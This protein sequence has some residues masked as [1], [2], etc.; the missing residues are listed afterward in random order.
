MTIRRKYCCIKQQDITDCGP[1]CIGTIAM[2]YG[3]KLS[4]SKLREI[5]GT[6]SEGTS[7]YGIME[8]A[9]SLGFSA[10]AVKVSSNEEIFDDLK[11]PLIAHVVVD[12][13]LLHYVVIHK[14]TKESILIA[15]PAKGIVKYTPKEF[16]DIWTGV[17]VFMVP[18]ADF[19]KGDE[20]KGL[21]ERFWGLIKI[22][23]IL[24]AE[25]FISSIIITLF[26]IGGSFYFQFLIDDILPNNLSQKLLSISMAMLVL[27]IFKILTEFFRRIL[28][29]HMAQ[30][31]DIPLLLGYYNHVINLPMKFFSTRK[32][33]EI[34][35]RFN[36]GCK[37]R[38]AISSATLTLM[39]DVLMAIVGGIILYIQSSKLFFICSVP[40]CLYLILVFGFK[41]N[42]E[43]VNRNVMEDDA[44]LTSYL[45][46]SIEGIETVKAFNGEK[47]VKIET[48]AKFM[49]FIKSLFK[50]AYIYNLQDT[51]MNAVKG[52]FGVCILWIGGIFVLNRQITI[53]ELISFNALLVYYIGPIERLINLQPQ[54]Q[55]AVVASDRLG[56]ILDLEL[57]KSQDEAKKINPKSLSGDIVLK[58]INFRYGLR[59]LV[60]KNI[61]ISIKP[62]EKIALVGES[63]SGKTT[64][65][66]LLM[67]FYKI[68]KGEIILNGYNIKDINKE[69][70]RDKISYVSQESFL[71]SG[72][73]KENLQFARKNL[74][75][76]DI[77]SICK[78][79]EIHDY[80]NRLPLKYE[81]PLVERGS[82]LSGGQRQRLS[83][84]RALL[85]NPDVLIMDEATSNLDSITEKAIQKTLEECSGNVTSII[86]AH[87]L[88]TIMKCDKIY[89]IDSGEIVEEGTHKELLKKRGYYYRLWGEQSI[90][91]LNKSLPSSINNINRN[92]TNFN[93]K[94]SLSI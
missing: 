83:I 29:I 13:I 10:K 8:A 63:G 4:L 28:L 58:D 6:D 94:N 21:F 50:H 53:G 57:E 72:T 78:N 80:I 31:I 91:K 40:I 56:D 82:N 48:E 54:L 33:G 26:G 89:V 47:K 49:K 3:L 19:K 22:Q 43:K 46:E 20:T 88:S 16:F 90:E 11:T 69:V 42:L 65:A 85:K 59:E 92:D 30:N 9:K 45:V 7:V 70:L 67:G 1:A 77:I 5:S 87:R 15:D 76:E 38:D 17:L 75:D 14:I 41:N 23:K 66:K 73:I 27:A 61:N 2:K 37:I 32:V 84:A 55:S 81:T 71:F 52:I 79:V 93:S 25:I 36:D 35:S 62:G 74:T 44:A 34:I 68:E 51:L 86:I 18:T 60:L 12:S 64:I 39:I 24:L